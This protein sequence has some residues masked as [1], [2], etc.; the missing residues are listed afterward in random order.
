MAYPLFDAIVG[1]LVSQKWAAEE[2]SRLARLPRADA[3]DEHDVIRLETLL[4]WVGR[5]FDPSLSLLGFLDEFTK[6]AGLHRRLAR[7]ARLG[8][9]LTTVN[10]DDL[11]ERALLQQGD[12]PYTLD[13]HDRIPARVPGVPVVKFHGT[14][15]R[16]LQGKFMPP[17]R[18]LHA[19]TQVIAEAN[20]NAFLN[21]RAA[22]ALSRSIDGRTLVVAGYSASDDLDIVPALQETRPARV[23]WIDHAECEP[24][25][26]R[27]RPKAGDAPAW[28]SLLSEMRRSGAEVTVL[29]GRTS[30]AMEELGLSD[31]NPGDGTRRTKRKP[32]WQGSI[33]RWAQSVGKH[34]PTGLGL[35]ALLFGDMGRYVLNERALLKSRPS[36]LPDGRWTAARRYYELGQTAL[37]KNPT[38][39]TTA[40]QRGLKAKRMAIGPAN[41][42]VAMHADLLLGRSA[43][44][45]QEYAKARRHFLDAR[46]F[47]PSGSIEWA[48][49]LAWL[50]RTEIWNR[51]PSRGMRNLKRAADIFRRNG[52]LEALLDA[53]E[54]TGLGRLALMEIAAAR[55]AL[56]EARN[57]ARSLGYVDRRFTTECSLAE[58]AALEG[59]TKIASRTLRAALSLASPDHS[60]IA[61]AWALLAE[62]EM[63]SARFR[64]AAHASR[65]ACACTTVVNRARLCLLLTN[66]AEAQYLSGYMAAS[67][68]TLKEAEDCPAEHVDPLGA[69]KREFLHAIFAGEPPPSEPPNML[70]AEKIAL[71]RAISR[72]VH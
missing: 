47:S 35:A 70:P 54:A 61:D 63:E 11:L 23:I 7:A 68:R 64:A 21:E 51:R 8:M 44:L 46:D 6:P 39:L 10:F 26:A 62:V 65:E 55:L 60:E 12:L 40:Y 58:A 57:L 50:G 33:K 53:V 59:E 36:P 22:S 45:Q 24:T 28:H 15:V 66:L 3:R 18:S 41:T 38:D 17:N 29:R 1:C 71:E 4:L 52:E 34:D 32:H 20:P 5:I 2:L 27:L 72:L 42:L 43:F 48:H 49:A 16:H 31:P 9:Q 25:R 30:G 37:L 56:T 14:R 19:T 67:S 69:A 13:A